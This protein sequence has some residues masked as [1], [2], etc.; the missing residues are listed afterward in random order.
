[1]DE[2]ERVSV[3]EKKLG[4]ITQAY[5]C[6]DTTK[7]SNSEE[8]RFLKS[9]V[10]HKSEIWLQH[11]GG[12]AVPPCSACNQIAVLKISPQFHIFFVLSNLHRE[13]WIIYT[14]TTNFRFEDGSG[15]LYII[16]I[17]VAD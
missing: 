9:T 6:L 4:K 16:Y 2:S 10:D 7:I 15:N 17:R 1:M 13:R 11:A 5:V 12:A 8:S 3:I 14:A